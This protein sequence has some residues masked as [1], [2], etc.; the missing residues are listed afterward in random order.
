MFVL[1]FLIGKFMLVQALFLA[2]S[3]LGLSSHPEKGLA[4]ALE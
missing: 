2:R 3:L 4:P 1:K